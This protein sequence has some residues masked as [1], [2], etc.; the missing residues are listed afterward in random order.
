MLQEEEDDDDDDDLIYGALSSEQDRDLVTEAE[1][2]VSGAQNLFLGSDFGTDE[3]DALIRRIQEENALDS[4]YETFA[5]ARSNEFESRVHALKKDAPSTDTPSSD[6]RPGGSIPKPLL[7]EDLHDEMDDW[8][9][10]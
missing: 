6:E 5:K 9:S 8:C 4:K 1:E 2:K 7:K 10:K 3:S